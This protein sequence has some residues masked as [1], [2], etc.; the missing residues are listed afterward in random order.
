MPGVASPCSPELSAED[1]PD[2]DELQCRLGGDELT[3]SGRGEC[4]C[5]QCLCQLPYFGTFCECNSDLCPML[6]PLTY[7]LHDGVVCSGSGSCS[8]SSCEC[9]AGFT[10][11]ACECPSHDGRCRDQDGGLCNNHGTCHCGRC[12]CFSSYLGELCEQSL[13]SAGLCEELKPCVLCSALGRPLPQCRTCDLITVEL[14]TELQPSQKLCRMVHSGC[15][16]RY[17]Y[18]AAEEGQFLV[19]VPASVVSNV[20]GVYCNK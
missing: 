16:L 7:G 14:T 19:A 5:G 2:D 15:L 18:E 3:C 13:Y 8:C 10:G 12:E 9:D 17:S 4:C 11:P 6:V 1:C 20:L